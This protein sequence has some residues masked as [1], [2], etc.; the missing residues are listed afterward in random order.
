MP[1]LAHMIPIFL[2][3]ARFTPIFAAS[4]LAVSSI[5]CGGA[6]DPTSS[7]EESNI[8]AAWATKLTCDDGAAVLEVDHASAR[9]VQ[10]VVRNADIVKFLSSKVNHIQNARH[11]VILTGR[12]DAEIT[13]GASF[14]HFVDDAMRFDVST[15]PSKLSS[16]RVLAEVKRDGDARVRLAFAEVTTTKSC[17]GHLDNRQACVDGVWTENVDSRELVNWG[18]Q[19]C[20]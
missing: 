12:A 2:H 1:A 4:L 18:F 7:S 13:D 16:T 17:S 19:N 11:E 6:D 15:S 5:A 8:T 10:F 14:T 20:R 3:P 9:N